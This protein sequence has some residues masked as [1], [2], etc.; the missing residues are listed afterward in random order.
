MARAQELADNSKPD[1]LHKHLDKYAKQLCPVI[2]VFGQTYHWSVRQIEYATDLIFK[3]SE[4]LTPLYDTLSREEVEEGG[5]AK[6]NVNKNPASRL[7][8]KVGHIQDSL[9]DLEDL[10][11]FVHSGFS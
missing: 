8:E 7:A 3:S 9:C 1:M 10:E 11:V 4:I 6:G 2:D 5:V